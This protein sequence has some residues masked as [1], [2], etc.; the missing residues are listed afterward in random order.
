MKRSWVSANG[1]QRRNGHPLPQVCRDLCK[2]NQLGRPY[3]DAG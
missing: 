3:A 2:L 1:C